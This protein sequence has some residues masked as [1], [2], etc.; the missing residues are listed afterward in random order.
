MTDELG[1]NFADSLFLLCLFVFFFVF[2]WVREYFITR[3]RKR[4]FKSRTTRGG[5]GMI[6]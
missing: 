2:F 3:K 6:E 1:R 4:E 5:G